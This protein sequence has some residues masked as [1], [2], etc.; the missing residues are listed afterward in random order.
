MKNKVLKFLK[1]LLI[2]R[3]GNEQKRSWKTTLIVTS[4]VLAVAIPFSGQPISFLVNSLPNDGHSLI[5]F[6]MA[7][8][9][10]ICNKQSSLSFKYPIRFLILEDVTLLH[11]PVSNLP[12]LVAKS[13]ENY[14]KTII[15]FTN[16]ENSLMFID[17]LILKLNPNITVEKIGQ[18]LVL[19][20][21]AVL[22]FFIF[23]CIRL[24]L[25]PFFAGILFISGTYVQSMTNQSYLFTLYP[26]LMTMVIAL[27]SFV[28][29]LMELKFH[30]SIFRSF[31]ACLLLG[32]LGAFFFNLRTSYLPFIIVS[33]LT[34]S[35]FSLYEI[36]KKIKST[37]IMLLISVSTFACLFFGFQSFQVLYYQ[38]IAKL[39]QDTVHYNRAYHVVGHPL[40]LGLSIPDNALSQREGI[41]W[42]DT[43]GEAL[44]KTIDPDAGYLNSNYERA[45]LT[46]Y[47]KLW[48]YYP[49]EMIEIYWKKWKLS[50]TGVFT[51][52]KQ[53][54]NTTEKVGSIKK[55]FVKLIIA[56]MYY[57]PNG[58]FYSILFI[59][60]SIFFMFKRAHWN[61]G[62]RV[63]FSLF[64]ITAFLIALEST[65]I[66]PTFY[67]Q[68][69][70]ALLFIILFL[71]LIFYQCLTDFFYKKII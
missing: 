28:V 22:M 46:Y 18:I 67:L 40:V 35:I 17:S 63:S 16:N 23:V 11:T 8:N 50:V 21:I 60:S 55:F 47:A 36:R 45:M 62:T 25:S 71:I 52:M 59:L 49:N 3:F 2:S 13:N 70:N 42:D 26:F 14:C 24:G 9:S 69:H 58:F 20:R 31:I 32:F 38:P 15:P 27:I 61:L 64:S 33:L 68:Y 6:E 57:I 12:S 44:A 53:S 1:W 56:P 7:L 4:L 51:F 5:S 54:I 37:K 39:F 66:S 29:L 48:I 10:C 19:I 41:R 30:Q 34:F 43:A 65:I